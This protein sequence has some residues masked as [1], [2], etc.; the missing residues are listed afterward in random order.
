[1]DDFWIRIFKYNERTEY[2]NVYISNVNLSLKQVFDSNPEKVI[3]D[4]KFLLKML[5]FSGVKKQHL[6]VAKKAT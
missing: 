2:S 3:T 6:Y 5:P 4:E 1:M